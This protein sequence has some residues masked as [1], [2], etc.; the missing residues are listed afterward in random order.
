MVSLYMQPVYV[1]VSF[2]VVHGDSSCTHP[3][4]L[5]RRAIA[6]SSGLGPGVGAGFATTKTA[7]ASVE[8]IVAKRM[9]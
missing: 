4:L 2:T 5:R 1:E 8:M 6:K 3:P 7:M 9:V